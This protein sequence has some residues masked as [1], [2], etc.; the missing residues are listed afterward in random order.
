MK[1]LILIL[2]LNFYV[3]VN[4]KNYSTCSL[5][6]NDTTTHST[7]LTLT[8]Y[9]FAYLNQL[10]SETTLTTQQ[11]EQ[12]IQD[13]DNQKTL[14]NPLKGHVS[15]SHSVHYDQVEWYLQQTDLNQQELSQ[16]IKQLL[17]QVNRVKVKRQDAQDETH[18]PW[19]KMQFHRIEPGSY[20]QIVY[21]NNQAI[22]MHVTLTHPFE[23]MDTQVTEKM[24]TE[25]MGYNNS[26]FRDSDR[27]GIV[28]LD[29]NGK[30]IRMIPD[31]PITNVTWWDAIEFANALSRKHGLKPVYK[32]DHIKYRVK[33]RDTS[34]FGLKQLLNDDKNVQAIIDAPNGNI[35][36]TEGYRLPTEAERHLI[37]TQRGR[38]FFNQVYPE[39]TT[40]NLLD[41]V[42]C[43]RNSNSS[44][45]EVATRKP[46]VIDGKEFFDLYGNQY[47]W[48]HRWRT[49]DD[50]RNPNNIIKNGSIEVTDPFTSDT[51]N[52]CTISGS[53]FS[54]DLRALNLRGSRDYWNANELTVYN[55]IRLVRSLPK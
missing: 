3:A 27:K 43:K 4:A 55:V 52:P 14:R 30:P 34:A 39:I 32:T 36:E 35:Y 40:E 49:N 50:I 15:S 6:L 11:L 2:N 31:L 21:E 48:T 28:S 12:L 10:Y 22:D 23:M 53:D 54:D 24:W 18:S 17:A 47:H 5:F 37:H 26:A 13:L 44:L 1:F 45:Q 16:K 9:F 46:F 29:I 42:W 33:Y 8:E 19:R 20:R 41:Y 25:V 7:P 38:L 51:P